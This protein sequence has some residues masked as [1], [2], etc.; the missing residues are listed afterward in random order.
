MVWNV[1]VSD[2]NGRR[3][4]VHNV[5]DHGRLIDFCRRNYKKNKDDRNEFCE[6]LRRDLMYC[7]WSKCEWE[8]ILQSWPPRDDFQDEKIDVWYQV[9]LNWDRFCEYVWDNRDEFKR[10]AK[11]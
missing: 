10:R 1:Y 3:I 8:I 4:V 7:Y 9:R 5:F 11:R 2:I 6:Q